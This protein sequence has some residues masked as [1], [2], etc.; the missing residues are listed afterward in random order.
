MLKSI[1]YLNADL[2]AS[3]A[4]RYACNLTSLTGM[5]INI[6]HVE[7]PDKEDHPPGSGWVRRTW[8]E[9][10]ISQAREKIVQVIA[11]EKDR[12]PTLNPPKIVLGQPESGVMRAMREADYDLFIV[13]FLHSFSP[14]PFYKQLHS[15]FFQQIKCPILMVKNPVEIKRVAILMEA[16]KTGP[17]QARMFARVFKGSGVPVDL[18]ACEFTKADVSGPERVE[19]TSLSAEATAAEKSVAEAVAILEANKCAPAVVKQLA[20]TPK[21][22]GDRLASYYLVLTSLPRHIGSSSP[23]LDCL[24]R[25]PSALLFC[26]TP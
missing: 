8:E 24:S 16:N 18:V 6:L 5:E 4:L 20:G 2:A 11:M 23:L 21:A 12:C 3:M 19:E 15:K 26:K 13:G 9:G 22:I 25:I 7:P 17:D 14:Q 10:L 1:V